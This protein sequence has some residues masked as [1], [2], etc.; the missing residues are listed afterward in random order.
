MKN[1]GRLI[2]LA[3]ALWGFVYVIPKVLNELAVYRQFTETSRSK[4]IDTRALFYSEEPHALQSERILKEK[5]S[6]KQ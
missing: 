2:V 6:A 3:L 5:L 1:W 4:G